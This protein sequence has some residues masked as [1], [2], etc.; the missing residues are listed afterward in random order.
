[1]AASDLYP[2]LT[3]IN[4]TIRNISPQRKRLTVF[5]TPIEY[6]Q[7]YDL[8]TIEGIAEDDIRSSLVKGELANKI[9]VGAIQI[10]SSSIN[11]LQFDSEQKAFIDSANA[12]VDQ[13]LPGTDPITQCGS[14][15]G[16]GTVIENGGTLSGT[17]DGDVLC[18]G[19]ATLVGNVTVNGNLKVLGNL[20]NSTR[21]N[22]SV[23]GS[24]YGFN[25]DFTSD[26]NN[27][28]QS[29]FSVRGD[30]F[31]NQIDFN[32]TAGS[33]A[34]LLVGGDLIGLNIFGGSTINGNGLNDTS[35][36]GIIVGGDLEIANLYLSGGPAATGSAG[37]GG[38]I[39]VCGDA[40]IISELVLNGGNSAI[41]GLAGGSGG[42]VIVLGDLNISDLSTNVS[43]IGKNG[44]QASG[45]NG[46]SITVHGN[47]LLTNSDGDLELFGGNCYSTNNNHVAG[48]GGN[49]SVYGNLVC[50]SSIEL[51]GGNRS[52]GL[53]SAGNGGN[54]IV[55]GNVVVNNAIDTTGG[56]GAQANAGDGGDINVSGSLCAQYIYTNGGNCNSVINTHSA[57]DGGNIN[58][59]S[60]T[61]DYE[62]NVNAGDRNGN[63][64]SSNLGAS[65]AIN[66][67]IDCLG[68]LKAETINGYGS[69]CNTNYPNCAGGTGSSLFV[70]GNMIADNIYL[71]GGTAFGNNGG[72]GGSIFVTGSV[73][74]TG[75]YSRGGASNNSVGV[76][77]DALVNGAGGNTIK[78]LNGF[79]AETIDVRDGDGPGTVPTN[80][81]YFYIT[82]SNHIKTL[83]SP[84]RAGC[85]IMPLDR[86][87][88]LKISTMTGKTTLNDIS[89]VASN[90]ISADVASHIYI[91]DGT[92][93]YG[94]AGTSIF[95]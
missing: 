74:A 90:N 65:T 57:G 59:K 35:G 86:T 83:L 93:W 71:T 79:N 4:F 43:L 7:T 52:G 14:G 48:S 42:D 60:I 46:G 16:G 38:A 55:K 77:G 40:N 66:G 10:V 44:S 95:I 84:D 13:P 76:G 78:A 69:S 92:T 39:F 32:Q 17:Y 1:M 81:I 11:L 68:D 37:N 26:N 82:G 28:A 29:S 87:A 24:L 88:T 41:T 21:N 19:E 91:S 67:N 23:L 47:A 20:I 6:L 22:L 15:G 45:G 27:L 8:M 25:I 3:S 34:T 12:D 70:G 49:I 63:T 75:I 18:K 53:G 9:R 30:L 89:E 31:F 85:L 61:V 50:D 54:F 36:L 64:T 2:K 5:N 58:A 56:N 72:N 51:N 73:Q 94:V 62:I 80:N 33:P